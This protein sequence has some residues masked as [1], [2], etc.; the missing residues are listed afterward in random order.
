MGTTGR[1]DAAVPS[2]WEVS[3]SW[4][5]MTSETVAYL[6]RAD[7]LLYRPGRTP[8]AAAGRLTFVEV[9]DTIWSVTQALRA[10]GTDSRG[11]SPRPQPR[12]AWMAGIARTGTTAHQTGTRGD[13][14]FGAHRGLR[15]YRR[16]PDRCAGRP[17]RLDGL[18]LPPS[19]R[20]AGLF[21]QVARRHR[22]RLL[23]H[24]P[25]LSAGPVN[26][27]SRCYRDD[28]LILETEF[29]TAAGAVRLVDCMPLRE[30]H[31]RV[32]RMVE[33]IRG[34]VEMRMDLVTRFD[35]GSVVPWVRRSGPLLTA[36]LVPTP[37]ACGPRSRC[38]VRA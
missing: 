8:I 13:N 11:P 12:H 9:G 28:T 2:G 27:I 19:V 14:Q 25:A 35:Y 16:H 21:R 20:L 33:C 26:R 31:P 15:G 30:S 1:P 7:H 29:E 10:L 5:G 24:G 22:E 6:T 32:M 3:S 4:D 17:G 34:R 36:S 18:A 37:S 23:A 38:E